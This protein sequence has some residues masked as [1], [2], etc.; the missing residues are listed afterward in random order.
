MTNTKPNRLWTT[1]LAVNS[2]FWAGFWVYFFARSIA[3]PQPL[4]WEEIP[5]FYAVFGR[6][7]PLTAPD[8]FHSV[9]FQTAFWS[10]LPCWLLTW[11]V[12]TVMGANTIIG[13]NAAGVRLI[14]ITALSYVQWYAAVRLVG[15]VVNRWMLHPEP[16]SPGLG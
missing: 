6:S 15:F 10:H 13:T 12:G 8:V 4:T 7:F 16:H 2:L 11:P 3:T 9:V 5:P 14:L 1:L